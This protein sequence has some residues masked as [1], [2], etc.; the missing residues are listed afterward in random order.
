M[1]R[2]VVRNR[3]IINVNG[4]I[5]IDHDLTHVIF[6]CDTSLIGEIML[7]PWILFG[8]NISMAELK[9]YG[10]V[11]DATAKPGSLWT[12]ETWTDGHWVHAPVGSFACNAFGLYD[13]HGNVWEWCRDD[14]EPSASYGVDDRTDPVVSGT[15]SVGRVYRGG[16]YSDSAR[17]ARSAR[18]SN[19]SPEARY[20]SL[21][22]RPARG[23]TADNSTTSPRQPR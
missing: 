10:N 5:F 8:C 16:S 13:V 3:P 6:G 4:K 12:C 2:A 23:I 11:A 14:S 22:L 21:G 7:K 20:N 9:A 1:A 17:Y 15:G 18:R 19:N